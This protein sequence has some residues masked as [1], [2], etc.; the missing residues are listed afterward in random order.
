MNLFHDVANWFVK[1]GHDTEAAALKALQLIRPI[2]PELTQAAVIAEK[3][4]GNSGLVSLTQQA[5]ITASDLATLA[6]SHATANDAVG[7]LSQMAQDMAVASGN[8][9]AIS[10]IQDAANRAQ[11]AL[12]IAKP[13]VDALSSHVQT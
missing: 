1:T 5:G 6:T 13:V 7:H 2:L 10:H 9:G 11:Q 3:A 4:T 8:Q 12:N